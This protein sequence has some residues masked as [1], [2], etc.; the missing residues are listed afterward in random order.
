MRKLYTGGYAQHHA[1]LL[2]SQ[3]SIT[4]AVAR[5]KREALAR[6]EKVE[7]CYDEIRIEENPNARKEA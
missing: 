3:Q 5:I 1:Q 6:G 7:G 4:E 2:H